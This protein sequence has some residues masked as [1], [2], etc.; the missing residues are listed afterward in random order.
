M[1]RFNWIGLCAAVASAAG[2]S[3]L[4][5]LEDKRLE[6]IELV[7]AAVQ[8]VIVAAAFVEQPRQRWLRPRRGGPARG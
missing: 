1:C 2:A 5:S 7:R 4:I 8:A 6:A 3:L